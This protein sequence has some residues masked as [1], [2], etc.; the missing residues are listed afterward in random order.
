MLARR[1]VSQPIPV[2]ET[3]TPV[4]RTLVIVALVIFV[5]FGI[6][7]TAKRKKSRDGRDA[8]AEAAAM[9]D[10]INNRGLKERLRLQAEADRLQE[11]R[12]EQGVPIAGPKE[13]PP[14]FS[15][16]EAH[17]A[18][19][20]CSAF[21]ELHEVSLPK[22]FNQDYYQE[23]VARYPA[24]FIA[25]REHLF[26]KRREGSTVH[27]EISPATRA[28]MRVSETDGGYVIHLGRRRVTDVGDLRGTADSARASFAYA[29]EER[30]AGEI[31]RTGIETFG[32][33]ASFVRKD[34]V[35]RVTHAYT[36]GENGET[37]CGSG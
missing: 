28:R 25:D 21:S 3:T 24:L 5:G 31:F 7:W 8:K 1:S 9:L 22:A 11:M 15:E 23:T 4:S 29:Y 26:D 14:N 6:V 13:P 36:S 37:I 35:W 12:R 17:A 32:G 18:I 27:L 33:H 20:Q 19:E 10:E 34:G 30:V 2:D 16:A